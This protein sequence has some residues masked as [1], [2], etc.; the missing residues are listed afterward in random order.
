MNAIPGRFHHT[1][2]ESVLTRYDDVSD[3]REALLRTLGTIS[4]DMMDMNINVSYD[5]TLDSYTVKVD[6]VKA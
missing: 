2:R 4:D 6:Y 5:E 3:G 1:N